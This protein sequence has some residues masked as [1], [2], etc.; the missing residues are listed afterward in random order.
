MTLPEYLDA[1]VA[2]LFTELPWLDRFG[3]ARAAGFTAVEFPWPDDPAASAA[4]VGD[5]GLAVAVLNMAAGDLAAGERGW[6]NDPGRIGEWRAALDDAVSLAG[7]LRC[8]SINVLAGNAVAGVSRAAQLECLLDNLA[9]ALPR[10]A[11]RGVTIVTEPLNRAENPDYL[12]VTL[13]D[14]ALLAERLAPLG[15]RLQLDL[16]HLGLTE[17]DV[18]AVIRRAGLLLRHL[19]VSD[20]PGRHE[21][22]S[23]GLDWAGIA[24]ALVAIGYAGFIGLEYRPAGSTVEGLA[25]V[26]QISLDP[27]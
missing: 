23:G 5:A 18:P 26:D 15:W 13:D 16:Y 10:A 11:A 1:N 9:W 20:L 12:V 22:G 2:W 21:P 4:A 8:R 25:W 3:A 7:E 24:D 6:P 17:A 19:Q 27:R 14:V